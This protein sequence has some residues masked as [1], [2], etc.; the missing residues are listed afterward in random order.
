MKYVQ[1]PDKAVTLT[2]SS[3]CPQRLAFYLVTCREAKET[4]CQLVNIEQSSKREI[5]LT[6]SGN[7]IDVYCFMNENNDEM[8]GS[9]GTPGTLR[10]IEVASSNVQSSPAVMFLHLY[11]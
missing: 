1:R 5:L 3:R 2:L 7:F 6:V 8:I 11:G 10:N 9:C 4:L